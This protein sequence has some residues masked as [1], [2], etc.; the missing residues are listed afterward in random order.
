MLQRTTLQRSRWVSRFVG[1]LFDHAF[2]FYRYNAS[3]VFTG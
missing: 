3:G 2:I 1:A